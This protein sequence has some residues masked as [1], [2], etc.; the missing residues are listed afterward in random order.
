MGR[1][2]TEIPRPSAARAG[3][4]TVAT[5]VVAEAA[6]WVLRPGDSGIEPAQVSPR[7]YFSQAALDHV[8][9]FAVGQRWLGL[10]GLAAQAVALGTLARGHPRALSR[11]LDVRR[12]PL[13]RAV[14][15]GAVVAVAAALA[16]LPTSIA[17]HQRAV[18][19][20][21]SSQTALSWFG[22]QGI[23][24]LIGAGLTAAG[25]GLL[26]LLIRRFPRRWWILAAAGAAAA[27]AAITL[28][29]P[30]LIAP[31]FN[32]F[33]KLPADSPLRAQVEDLGRR[34]GVDVGSVYLVDASKRSRA[35][36]AYVDGLGPTKRVVLYDTLVDSS[37]HAE[38]RSVVAHELGHVAHRDVPRGIA[39][40][41]IVAPLG[42][43]FAG[44][45]TRLITRRRGLELSSPAV[46]PALL[47]AIG[48]TSFLLSVPGNQLSR[49]V[50]A[51]ADTFALRLTGDPKAMIGLERRF[52][53]TNLANPEPP[54]LIQFLF[55]SHPTTLQRIGAAVAWEHGER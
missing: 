9:S 49:K 19:V 28:L 31:R 14:A 18:D 6:Q 22:D 36:N 42:M 16:T 46:V 21:L 47:F 11:W 54:A 1:V 48:L 20:G 50:E 30:V 37:D 53:T 26:V 4:A 41:T 39:F 55:G 51:S 32:D 29:G 35:V 13:L 45:L 3:L 17:A 38:L 7:D 15:A 33:T 52:V 8:H 40:A 27:G 25:A 24:V 10:A 5:I 34:A 2:F 12:R 43:L 44:G 23:S